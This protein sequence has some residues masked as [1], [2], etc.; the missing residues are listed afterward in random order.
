MT[1]VWHMLF[2]SSIY[3]CMCVPSLWRWSEYMCHVYQYI[4]SHRESMCWVSI[5]HSLIKTCQTQSVVQSALDRL[6][7]AGVKFCV[8]FCWKPRQDSQD[9]RNCWKWTWGHWDEGLRRL[10]SRTRQLSVFTPWLSV[11][12]TRPKKRGTP[13]FLHPTQK[14]RNLLSFVFWGIWWVSFFEETD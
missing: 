6:H 5:I 13:R 8:G 7:P 3:A 2:Y 1:C 4:F 12:Y 11:V 9:H 14:T 10:S